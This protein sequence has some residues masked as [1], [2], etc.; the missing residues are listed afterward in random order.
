ME[1]C[2]MLDPHSRTEIGFS[3]GL[4]RLGG[5]FSRRRGAE[6]KHLALQA[7]LKR[8]V[9]GETSSIRAFESSKRY[10]DTEAG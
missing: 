6:E 5:T 2:E 4:C 9:T 10:Y 3:L 1:Q 7:Y 8:F